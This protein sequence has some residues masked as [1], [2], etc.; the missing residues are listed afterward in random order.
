MTV[1][2]LALKPLKLVQQFGIL[3]GI[4]ILGFAFYDVLSPSTLCQLQ[5]NG[6]DLFVMRCIEGGINGP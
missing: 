2:L 1:S 6:H 3:V 5:V 4:A